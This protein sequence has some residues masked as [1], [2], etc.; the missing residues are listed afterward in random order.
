MSG[1]GQELKE[2]SEEE[3]K[4]LKA[5]AKKKARS[6]G[7]LWPSKYRLAFRETWGKFGSFRL[8]LWEILGIGTVI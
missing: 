8:G 1:C 5:E 6:A 7:T 2:L 3:R 4:K